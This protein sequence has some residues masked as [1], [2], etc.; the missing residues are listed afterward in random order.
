[1]IS[2]PL[3]SPLF[4]STT[5]F[6]SPASPRCGRRGP[7]ARHP[8]RPPTGWATK[9]VSIGNRG[10]GAR[11]EPLWTVPAY[12]GFHWNDHGRHGEVHGRSEEHTSELQSRSDLVCRI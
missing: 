10:V 6:R 1:L 4:P 11:G 12:D 9:R 8:S 2:P 3:P 5:L 7:R